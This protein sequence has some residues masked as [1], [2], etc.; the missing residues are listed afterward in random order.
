M[1]TLAMGSLATGYSYVLAVVLPS[2]GMR[3]FKARQ[4]CTDFAVIAG[5]AQAITV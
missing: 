2:V 4:T 5:T 1:G 3:H